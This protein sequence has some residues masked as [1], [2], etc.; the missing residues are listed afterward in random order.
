MNRL[1][2]SWLRYRDLV[3]IYSG[4]FVVLGLTAILQSRSVFTLENITTLL[5]QIAPY[6]LAAMA[7]T[8][9]MLLG[10]ID[11]SVG[12]M[13]SLASTIVATNLTHGDANWL[14][15]VAVLLLTS[16]LGALTGI[17]INLFKLPAIIV[18]LA[19]SFIWGGVALRIL[20]TPGGNVPDS[21]SLWLVGVYGPV[22]MMAVILLFCFLLWGYLRSTRIGL[23]IYSVGSNPVGARATGL[24]SW[25]AHAWAY[26]LSG[27][28][29]GLAGVALSA[30]T[31]S[32]NSHIGDPLTLSS[33]AA[34]VLGGVSFFGGEG[35]MAGSVAG[36]IVLGMLVNLLFYAGF[37][38]FYQ[39]IAEGVI[40]LIVV[41]FTL[42]R[43]GGSLSAS[44]MRG[45]AATREGGPV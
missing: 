29:A 38:S 4:M 20:P 31:S 30:Q 45:A 23:L 27:F 11:L 9:I 22:P 26:G 42:W 17:L 16:L 40:L 19:T 36:A 5:V 37:T 12:A 1:R 24:S 21:V 35:K 8:M 7:Q 34:A 13:I 32:G 33:I 18:T 41:G 44:R 14:V 10:G 3:P 39:Y 6:I 28:F 15:I 2:T 25:L 43:R